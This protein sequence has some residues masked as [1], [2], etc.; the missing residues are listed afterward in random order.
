M[1]YI[2]CLFNMGLQHFS[3]HVIPNACEEA[4]DC[5]IIPSQ[6]SLIRIITQTGIKND[7]LEERPGFDIILNF[8]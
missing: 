5:E 8:T 2:K 4:K 1:Y 6:T 7:I 3:L